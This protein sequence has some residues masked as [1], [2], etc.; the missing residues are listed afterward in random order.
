MRE[1]KIRRTVFS[2]LQLVLII[3]AFADSTCE[4]ISNWPKYK[5]FCVKCPISKQIAST[6]HPWQPTQCI[7]EIINN[8]MY[9][10]YNASKK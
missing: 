10:Q 6:N 1:K 3:T 8:F 2:Y 5:I 7:Q 4:R 9:N